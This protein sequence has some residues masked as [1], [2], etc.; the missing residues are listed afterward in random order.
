MYGML[1]QGAID[2]YFRLETHERYIVKQ[3][4]MTSLLLS[5]CR[6]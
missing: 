4:S 5:L 3:F 1:W 2:M 6:T